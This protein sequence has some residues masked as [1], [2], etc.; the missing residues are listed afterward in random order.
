M[1]VTHQLDFDVPRVL[2]EFFHED[3]GTAKRRKRF[4]SGLFERRV[5]FVLT[6]DDS[7][8]ATATAMSRFKDQ[9]IAKVGRLLASARY[10]FDGFVGASENRDVGRFRQLACRRLVA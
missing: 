5:E 1:S 6:L 9:R 7:H 4:A 3:I 8:A 10:V 2:D